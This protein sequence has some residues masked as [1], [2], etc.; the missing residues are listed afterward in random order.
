MNKVER[1]LI[2]GVVHADGVVQDVLLTDEQIGNLY[3]EYNTPEELENIKLILAR[4]AGQPE[5]ILYPEDELIGPTADD[6]EERFI[7]F[8]NIKERMDNGMAKIKECDLVIANIF[9]SKRHAPKLYTAWMQGR[10]LNVKYPLH[11]DVV[12]RFLTDPRNQ[13]DINW[14]NYRAKCW[15]LWHKLNK[16][17]KAMGEKHT[18]LWPAYYELIGSDNTKYNTW[19][20]DET[21]EEGKDNRILPTDIAYREAH[22]EEEERIARRIG[23]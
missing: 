9:K 7:V 19:G 12:K 3:I 18:D 8:L 2:P 15:D 23:W 6:F 16:E 4:A 1:T 5:P 22:M 17:L 13:K 14:F 10:G 20:I 21:E 11:G